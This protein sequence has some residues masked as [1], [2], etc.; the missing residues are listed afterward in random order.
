VKNI[1]IL[2]FERF[3]PLPSIIRENVKIKKSYDGLQFL[4]QDDI[5]MDRK[6]ARSNSMD[7]IE[8]VQYMDQ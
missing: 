7:Y 6:K 3:C 5:N 8:L 2:G 4:W 1:L